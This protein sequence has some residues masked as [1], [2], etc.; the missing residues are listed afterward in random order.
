MTADGRIVLFCVRDRGLHP[1]VRRSPLDGGD[2]RAVLGGAGRVVAG[3]S[4]AGDTAVV[5]LGDARRRSARSSLVDLA[6]GAETVADRARRGARRRRARS[7]ARSATFTI[8][9]GTEV[10]AWLVR[11][12][13]RDRPAPAAARHP[14]RPAQRLERRRRRDAP[15]PPGARRPRLDRPAGQPARQRRLRRGVLRRRRSAPGAWPT[16][17]TSS[18][19]STQL[20]AEGIADPE[21]LAVTGYS[22][23]G[24]MTCYLTGHDDRFAAAV[25]GGVVSDLVSMGGTCDDGHFLS[26]LR[27]RRHAVGRPPTRYAAM[28]PLHAGRQGRAR[29]TLVLHGAADLALPR[30]PGPA[31]AHRAA[32]ARRPDP[33]G[34]LPGRLATCSSCSGPPSHRLDYNR[35]VVDWVEQYAGRGGRARAID[36]A[37]WQRRLAALAEA[38]QGARRPAR[39]PALR[40]RRARTSWSRRAYGVLNLATGRPGDRPTRCSRSA[41][42]P[43]SGRRRSSCSWSTRACS[44]STPRSSRCCPSSGSPTPTS[45]RAS[46]IR[47][48][49]T[50]TSGIDGDVFTDTG[51]GDDCLEKYVDAARRR[52]AEPPARRHLVLLQLR[53]LAA[54]PGDREAHRQDLGRRRCAS[55]SFT[56]LG[57]DQH[58]ARC[59]RRRCCTRA[60]VGHVDVGRRAG[61]DARSGG[62]RAR[63][64]RPG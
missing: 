14:R 50:H 8:S 45:P 13:E 18:S 27:A 60:A 36:A 21:R 29:P 44:S 22:Y 63:S 7:R 24:F 34:A 5:A 48:L 47:H 35:R 6:T 58:R 26:A 12:P 62:C 40:A 56:P 38:A 28:S 43:R 55:G 25:A 15:L 4:V 30:R 23:G 46:R 53:L 17:T 59:P 31:V 49:L 52:G 54:R 9:D 51:R 1:P 2:A 33:A 57:L 16:P 20:V 19:R 32:R 37:H 61:P 64:A 11:D 10:Q 3:L 42:S 41:R 39:H